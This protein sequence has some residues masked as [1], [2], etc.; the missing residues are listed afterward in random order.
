MNNGKTIGEM[1]PDTLTL[2]KRLLTAKVGEQ[3]SYEELSGLIGADVTERRGP[4]TSAIRRAQREKEMVFDSVRGQGIKRLDDVQIATSATGIIK[5]VRRMSEKAIKRLTC[6]R[7]FAAMPDDAQVKH[8]A[9]MSILA[10]MR[11]VS[12]P[13]TAKKVEAAV[14]AAKGALPL[15]KTLEVFK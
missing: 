5:R 3:I 6:V 2:Y 10:V 8:N 7:D 14:T 9:G 13:A 1:L 15:A 12:T 11:Q 4:L